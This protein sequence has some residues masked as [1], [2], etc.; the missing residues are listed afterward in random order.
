MSDYPSDWDQFP[1][2]VRY[3]YF[4]IYSFHVCSKVVTINCFLMNRALHQHIDIS[5]H[6][7]TCMYMMILLIDTSM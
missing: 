7:Y 1:W 3:F 2:T 5:P 6:V 4:H